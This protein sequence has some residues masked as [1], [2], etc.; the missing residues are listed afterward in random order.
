MTNV[1]DGARSSDERHALQEYLPALNM[2]DS[3]Y[4]QSM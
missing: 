3:E 1:L 4:L 2:S